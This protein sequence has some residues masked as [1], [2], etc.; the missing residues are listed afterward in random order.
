MNLSEL[1]K[2]LVKSYKIGFELPNKKL[3]PSHYTVTGIGEQTSNFIDLSGKFQ[4]NRTLVLQL[5]PSGDYNHR[6]HPEKLLKLLELAEQSFDTENSDLTI[7]YQSESTTI[8]KLEASEKYFKLLPELDYSNT[9]ENQKVNHRQTTPL[10][11]A[12]S[13]PCIPGNGCC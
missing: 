1:K 13:D 3:V 4:K 5:K 6:L 11:D 2:I 7:A 9:I 10:M 8:Y 12:A